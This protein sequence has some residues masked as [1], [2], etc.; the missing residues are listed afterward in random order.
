MRKL[1][2]INAVSTK[3]GMHKVD[4][5]TCL[6]AILNEIKES[7]AEDKNVYLRGFGSFVIKTRKS[8]IG[9]NIRLQTSV[10]IPEKRIITLK[11]SPELIES[12]NKT[13]T[14][15]LEN[16]FDAIVGKLEEVH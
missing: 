8:K 7:L 11:A 13:S 4:V 14:K 3:T 16:S 10:I 6:D 9:R 5:I 15:Q 2:I 12:I 1:D